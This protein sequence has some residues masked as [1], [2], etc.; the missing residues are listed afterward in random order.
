MG[1]MDVPA[2]ASSIL[3]KIPAYG[4]FFYTLNCAMFGFSLMDSMMPLMLGTPSEKM[5]VVTDPIVDA[6]FLG[7]SIVNVALGM[8]IYPMA[9]MNQQ[10]VKHQ[11]LGAAV[12]Y[13]GFLPVMFLMLQGGMMGMQGVAMYV[14]MNGGLGA[15]SVINYMAL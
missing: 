2:F 11:Q 13:I 14:V 6:L 12:F 8:L 3:Y 7:Y 4:A 15:V 1:V 5:P 9:F 10:T